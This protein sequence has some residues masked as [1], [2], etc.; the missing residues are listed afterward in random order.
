MI[1]PLTMKVG[2]IVYGDSNSIYINNQFK[3]HDIS[4]SQTVS[5]GRMVYKLWLIPTFGRKQMH[6]SIVIINTTSGEVQCG[7]IRRHMSG[8][9][10]FN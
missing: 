2:D 8:Q 9:R 7:E 1:N 6:T 5:L 3:I 10:R 4:K